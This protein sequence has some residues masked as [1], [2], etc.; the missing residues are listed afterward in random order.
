MTTRRIHLS[1]ALAAILAFGLLRTP[2]ALAHAADEDIASFTTASARLATAQ[3][4]QPLVALATN[5]VHDPVSPGQTGLLDIV[6]LRIEADH[7]LTFEISLAVAGDP[8]AEE[9]VINLVREDE[10]LPAL[11]VLEVEG[12][13]W[14]VFELDLSTFAYVQVGEA[15]YSRDGSVLSVQISPDDLASCSYLAFVHTSGVSDAFEPVMDVAP[16][17]RRGLRVSAAGR[18]APQH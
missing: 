13:G 11:S 7:R 3:R 17:N 15:I 10:I 12:R 1:Y 8:D 14:G 16:N 2:L 9:L 5:Q 18:G 4:E 6:S